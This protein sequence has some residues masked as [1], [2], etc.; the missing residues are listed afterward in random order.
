MYSPLGTCGP[1]LSTLE[2]EARLTYRAI[3]AIHTLAAGVEAPNAPRLFWVETIRASS[4]TTCS[5]QKHL[6]TTAQT[7]V[8]RSSVT[9][10]T[11]R[12]ARFTSAGT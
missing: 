11:R 12:V 9:A 2:L 10:F 3:D 1:A 4:Y 8:E 7:V 6:A 5:L